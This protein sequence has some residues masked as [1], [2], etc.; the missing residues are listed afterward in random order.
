MFL[1]SNWQKCPCGY[2]PGWYCKEFPGGRDSSHEYNPD[3][4][5]NTATG[6]AYYTR[7]APG[8]V[9]GH[10]NGTHAEAHLCEYGPAEMTRIRFV[11]QKFAYKKYGSRQAAFD[12]AAKWIVKNVEQNIFRGRGT[13]IG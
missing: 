12:A 5:P 10:I 7:R 1:D 6:K 4:D 3:A 9:F 11:K 8:L 2:G 13:W